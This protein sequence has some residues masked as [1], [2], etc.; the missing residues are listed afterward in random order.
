VHYAHGNDA[1]ALASF[2]VRLLFPPLT[3][4]IGLLENCLKDSNFKNHCT[5][6]GLIGGSLVGLAG[7]AAADALLFAREDFGRDWKGR[8]IR[9]GWQI[10]TVDAIGYGAGIAFA[11]THPRTRAGKTIHPALAVWTFGYSIGVIGAPIVHFVHGE[12]GTG[13]GSFG[14]RLLAG[15]AG[16]LPGLIGYCAA[17]GGAKDCVAQGAQWG[18]LGGAIAASL[19]DAFVLARETE[20]DAHAQANAP[21]LRLGLGTIGVAGVW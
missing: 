16:A 4:T 15:P 9:Y 12:V 13:F 20:R 7:V 3:A 21:T 5:D 11:F 10:M 19:L 17:S 6:P 18:L 8:G 14:L 1:G 2:G